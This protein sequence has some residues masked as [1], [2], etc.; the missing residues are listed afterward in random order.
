MDVFVARQAIFDRKHQVYAYELLYRSDAVTNEFDGTEA[1]SATA[2]VVAN[3]LLAVGLDNMLGG[4][5]AFVN[6]DRT[7]LIGGFHAI[8][9]PD[10]LVVEILESVEADLAVLDACRKLHA[11]G[12]LMALDDFVE[13]VRSEALT[14][15]AKMIKVDVQTTSRAEQERIINTYKPRG[16]AI[17]AEKVETIEEFEWAKKAG[18]EYFQGYYFARPV[19]VRGR[20]IPAAKLACLRLLSEMQSEELDYTRIQKVVSEDVAL[21]F[22]L[23]RYA[24]SALFARESEIHTID[25]AVVI[26]GE[27]GLRHWAALAAL[28]VLAKD[29]PGELIMHS[30]LRAR[31]CE[32]VL[33]LA[34]VARHPLGFLMG[35]FSLLD[36]LVDLPLP[37]ALEQVN[38]APE[39]RGALLG[40]APADDPF[41]SVFDMVCHYEAAD[42]DAV[43]AG[44]VK[45]GIEA[46]AVASAYGASVLWAQQSLHATSRMTDARKKV[47]H[48]ASGA[49][50]ILWQDPNGRERISNAQLKNVSV[51]GLQLQVTE[52]I[53]LRTYVTCNEPKL[54]IGG[55][56][57]VRYCNHSKGKYLIGLE[58]SGGTG[59][60]D[61]LSSKPVAVRTSRWQ[62]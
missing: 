36:A 20:H 59:W 40:T 8:L 7:L 58:F 24:N 61:P 11:Q 35:L 4:R 54:G 41:R 31:F 9:P 1:A 14:R 50:R 47:R 37:E 28:P 29:K 10:T 38:L 34:S 5:K 21:S 57:M 55:R 19:V 23:M 46:S 60:R 27:S 62:E 15:I 2:Q 25:H 39:L 3:S 6:F 16:I 18:Y 44:A 12:Y 45:L 53:P 33:Q 43:H 13:D 22:K 52:Q 17:L 51:S 32:R 26:L 42:W 30:L 49:L 56:G 48:L